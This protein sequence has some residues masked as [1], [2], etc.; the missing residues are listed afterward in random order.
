MDR[1]SLLSAFSSYTTQY[2]E[3]RLFISAF[4]ELIEN[5][6]DCFERSLLSGHITGSAWI[7]NQAFSKALL[8]H[9][10]KLGR[11]LQPGG[12]A[13]GEE[14]I[15]KVAEMELQEETGLTHAKVFSDSIFDIDIH[16]IPKHKRVPAHY[17]YDIRFLFVADENERIEVSNE[18][19]EVKW[20]PLASISELV[21]DDR[22]ILRM[23]E[24]SIN[25][26]RLKVI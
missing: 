17:H 9:H 15:S 2:H 7:L 11:W 20:W 21:N 24:K 8:V 22:S 19:N 5:N 12:H 26:S 1:G 25:L 16:Q 14:N 18:S 13:D 4:S 10:N 3:E 23:V 6:Q